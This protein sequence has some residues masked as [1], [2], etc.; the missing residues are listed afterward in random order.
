MASEYKRGEVLGQGAFGTVYKATRTCALKSID[1][2][3][4]RD[5]ERAERKK[6]WKQEVESLMRVRGHEN[7]VKYRNSFAS[8]DN[9]LW[10]ELEYCNGGTLNDYAILV[11]ISNTD[12][13][14]RFHLVSLS[15]MRM[16]LYT[17]I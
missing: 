3:A 1:I 10:L 5:R 13:C 9:K 6:E 15:F 11:V 12:S 8:F 2:S 14:L 7:I 4:L 16:A 17:V